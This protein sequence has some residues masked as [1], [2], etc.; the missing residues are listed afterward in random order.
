MGWIETVFNGSSGV[1]E[2]CPSLLL[3]PWVEEGR[4]G[5]FRHTG[6]DGARRSAFILLEKQG[7]YRCPGKDPFDCDQGMITFLENVL[8]SRQSDLE[9]SLINDSKTLDRLEGSVWKK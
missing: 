2:P 5:F 1:E 8:F 7:S 3:L 6:A 9:L 4:N